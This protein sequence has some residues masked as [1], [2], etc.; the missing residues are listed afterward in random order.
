MNYVTEIYLDYLDNKE[1]YQEI[2]NSFA[3]KYFLQELTPAQIRDLITKQTDYLNKLVQHKKN[4]LAKGINSPQIMSAVDAKIKTAGATI[5]KLHQGMDTADLPANLRTSPR[6]TEP[7]PPSKPLEPGQLPAGSR[8]APRG[9]AKIDTT[10]NPSGERTALPKG[11]RTGPRNEP[12]TEPLPTPKTPKDVEPPPEVMP[13]GPGAGPGKPAPEPVAQ[14]AAPVTQP[15]QPPVTTAPVTQPA[16]PPAQ[17]GAWDQVTQGAKNIGSAVAG[18]V[19]AADTALR[20]TSVGQQVTQAV[21]PYATQAAGAAKAGLTKLGV[22]QGTAGGIGQAIQSIGASPLGLAAL[23]GAAAYGGYKLYKRFLSK[24][25]TACRGYSGADK[26][27][28]MKSF[29]TAKRNQAA[30]RG[31]EAA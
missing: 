23:G 14:P 20:G 16:Q 17:P 3:I 12:G 4:L 24:S 2:Y 26:T 30:S 5:G 10:V 15:A 27:A 6:G 18:K 21:Q 29:M 11:T 13:K 28:C 19:K 22:S 7:P 1:V 25:A 8:T 9:Q 31:S